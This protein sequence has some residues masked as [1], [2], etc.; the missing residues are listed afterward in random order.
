LSLISVNGAAVSADITILGYGAT[1]HWSASVNSP[2]V[3]HIA[4]GPEAGTLKPGTSATVF[5]T[6]SATTTFSA[7]IVFMP[8]DHIV[9]VTVTAKKVVTKADINLP[10][11]TGRC[12]N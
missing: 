1:V 10:A 12:G 7:T 6:A 2:A 3:G 5:V 11:L 9:T 8:G 4:I